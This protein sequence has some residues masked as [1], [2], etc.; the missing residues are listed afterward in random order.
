MQYIRCMI[1]SRFWIKWGLKPKANLTTD[2]ANMM[3]DARCNGVVT[4]SNAFKQAYE[5]CS[6][7]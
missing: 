7:L 2:Q 4:L 3:D 6:P 1:A 5:N